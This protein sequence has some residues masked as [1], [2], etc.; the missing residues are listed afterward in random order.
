MGWINVRSAFGGDPTTM[1]TSTAS[2]GQRWSGCQLTTSTDLRRQSRLHHR[3]RPHLRPLREK[4]E[5]VLLHFLAAQY[6]MHAV[7]LACSRLLGVDAAT[8]A[9]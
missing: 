5:A 2:P 6:R 8:I 1:P 3:R 7:A 9:T 4:G